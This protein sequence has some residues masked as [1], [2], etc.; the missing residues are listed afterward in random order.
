MDQKK[1]KRFD[2][3]YERHLQ[4]LKL[5]GKS[6]KTRDAYARAI[7]RLR[8]HFDCCP[9]KLTP[10][11]LESYFAQLVETHSWSTVTVDCWGFKFFFN[12]MMQQFDIDVL[13]DYGVTGFPDT[14]KVI[15][16]TWR[17]LNRSRNSLVNKRRYRRARFA[18][19]TMYPETSDNPEK[20][21]AWLK[22]KPGF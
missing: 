20:Y 22:K 15:N 21:N 7:R 17:E 11:Q 12:Y 6:E 2:K 10:K 13:L 1:T 5:Q 4:M 9:D 16:P 3:L 18:E 8:D 19:M 14:E